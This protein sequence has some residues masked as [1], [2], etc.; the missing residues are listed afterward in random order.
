MG[1]VINISMILFNIKTTKKLKGENYKRFDGNPLQVIHHHIKMQSGDI[2]NL[3]GL[4][5]RKGLQYR[6]CYLP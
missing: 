5:E 6:R 3:H 1:F 4:V 2:D